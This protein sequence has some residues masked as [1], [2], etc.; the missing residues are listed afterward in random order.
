MKVSFRGWERE[1]YGLP[2]ALIFSNVNNKKKGNDPQVPQWRYFAA[3]RAKQIFLLSHCQVGQKGTLR[4]QGTQERSLSM[5]PSCQH[6]SSGSSQHPRV[7]VVC[8]HRQLGTAESLLPQPP[9]GPC[10]LGHNGRARP[11]PP[12]LLT[13]AQF[14]PKLMRRSLFGLAQRLRER[15]CAH[16]DGGCK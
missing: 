9:V 2:S 12:V 4:L 14:Q 15:C 11:K 13:A 3:S 7:Q 5:S 10:C 1:D 8:K 16:P 6:T